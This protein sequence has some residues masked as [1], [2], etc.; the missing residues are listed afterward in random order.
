MAVTRRRVR[1]GVRLMVAAAQATRY[2]ADCRMPAICRASK[3]CIVPPKVPAAAAP[4]APP[5]AT[6][7]RPITEDGIT[8]PGLSQEIR[9]LAAHIQRVDD[10]SRSRL[11]EFDARLSTMERQVRELRRGPK[12]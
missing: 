5:P 9:Q 12:K 4:I 2:C 8:L 10:H 3:R 1:A 6:L 11:A 7:P